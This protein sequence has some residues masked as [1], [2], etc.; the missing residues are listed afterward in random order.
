[1]M[2]LRYHDLVASM[3]ASSPMRDADGRPTVVVG[4]PSRSGCAG[5]TGG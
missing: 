1:M 4:R 3:P 2:T 5:F